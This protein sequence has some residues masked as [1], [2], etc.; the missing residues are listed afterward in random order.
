M[1]K[2][3]VH[4]NSM[5][6]IK[7]VFVHSVC[8]KKRYCIF[9][10][11]HIIYCNIGKCQGQKNVCVQIS[12]PLLLL[13]E[14]Q[15]FSSFYFFRYQLYFTDHFQLYKSYVQSECDTVGVFYCEAPKLAELLWQ[16]YS[17]IKLDLSSKL[18]IYLHCLFGGSGNRLCCADQQ[19]SN[20]SSQ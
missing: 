14:S 11:L 19:I 6:Q 16:C 4:Q 12:V 8:Q 15:W 2:W 3:S 17:S 10:M 18:Q 20:I 13:T 1:E 9:S 7:C 5:T